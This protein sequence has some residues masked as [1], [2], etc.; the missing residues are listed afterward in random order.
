M[1]ARG[2]DPQA[3]RGW[4]AALSTSNPETPQTFGDLLRGFPTFLR[5]S[6]PSVI[7]SAVTAGVVGYVLNIWIMAVKYQGTNDI[8]K[9]TP[10]TTGDNL[11]G[12]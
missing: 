9:G 2:G 1:E 5:T 11:L 3:G 12:G 10:V 6:L 7:A 4:V 8:P